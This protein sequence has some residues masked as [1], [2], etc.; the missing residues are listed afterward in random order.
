[1][2]RG[3][4]YVLTDVSGFNELFENG[5]PKGSNIPLWEGIQEKLF[6]CLQTH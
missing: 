4:K 3:E 5:I 1:M 2:K 6:F